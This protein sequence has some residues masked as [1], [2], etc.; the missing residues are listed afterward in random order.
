MFFVTS[1]VLES[2]LLPSNVIGFIAVIG[3]SALLLRRFRAATW[4]LTTAV[5]SFFIVGWSPLGPALIAPLENR[6]P[7]PDLPSAVTGIVMLGGA[8]D[9]HLTGDR[10]STALNDNA[11]RVFATAV[12]AR[13]Y[14][15]A[16]ILLSGGA[17][18]L[19]A[20]QTLNES[21]VA[22]DVLVDMGIPQERIE[23]EERS[24]TTFENA[25][26]SLSVAKP[27]SGDVWLL[28][29]SAYNMP[30]AVA[31]FEAVRFPVLPYPVDYRT[32]PTDMFK[33]TKSIAE[34]MTLT[35]VAAHEW[36]GLLAYWLSGR[37][38]DLLPARRAGALGAL[39]RFG[40]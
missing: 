23:M 26:E 16:R 4:L 12:L 30:R 36:L 37:T 28:V 31:S 40:L 29:T 18:H 3:V 39:D 33:P 1:K 22:R 17:N 27:K 10:H 35:D 11:E 6:F 2:A 19:F 32:R 8:V 9:T 25:V 21:E 38:H 34:G 14:P 13:R 5:A 20:E 24:R 7:I 15:H